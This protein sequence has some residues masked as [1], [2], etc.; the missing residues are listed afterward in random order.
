M[1]LPQYMGEF[2]NRRKFELSFSTD[3]YISLRQETKKG[4][5]FVTLPLTPVGIQNTD[6]RNKDRN[7]KYGVQQWTRLAGVYIEI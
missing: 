2:G 1:F 6:H 7:K 4:Q 5:F 3:I